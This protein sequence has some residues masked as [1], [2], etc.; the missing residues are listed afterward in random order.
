MA[1]SSPENDPAYFGFTDLHG[2]KDFVTEAI[3]CAPDQ[4]MPMDWLGPDE[5]MNLERAFVGLR[6]GLDLTAAEKGESSLL[7][8]C[9]ALVEAA[10]GDYRAGRD[11]DGRHKLEELEALLK[12]L[13]TR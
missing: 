2:F 10:Y 7:A 11:D 12:T 9:R 1:S 13:P 6:Y 5:Q 8:Q 4:F 3:V